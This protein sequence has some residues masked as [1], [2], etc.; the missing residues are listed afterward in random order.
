MTA[1]TSGGKLS[2]RQLILIP[3]AFTLAVTLVRLVGELRHWSA[4][5][6]T[7]DM[8]PSI[9]AIVWLAPV[10]GAYFALRLARRGDGPR[11][12]WRSLL[13][14]LLGAAIVMRQGTIASALHLTSTP[15][16]YQRLVY[17]W[18]VLAVAALV[19]LPGWPALFK[20]MAAYAYAARVPVAIIMFFAM[21]GNWGT[22]Y[23]LAPSDLPS[24]ISFASKYLWIA[25]LPQL[26]FWVGFT[27]LAGMLFGSIAAAVARLVR[28]A[29]RMEAQSFPAK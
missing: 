11:S 18:A 28:R 5:W 14:P 26:V 3:A 4:S 25:F 13:F 19:S 1:T 16:F 20:T 22:H 15:T 9:V 12:T 29:P 24:G 10:F 27:V 6:F 7:T 8:G 21:R 2:T 23:G 17:V